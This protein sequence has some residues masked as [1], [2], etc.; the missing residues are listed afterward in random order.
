MTLGNIDPEYAWVVRL[1]HKSF[2]KWNN[3]CES[4]MATTQEF[5][6]TKEYFSGDES[7]RFVFVFRR[8]FKQAILFT[9]VYINSKIFII[10][11]FHETLATR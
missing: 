5:C 2:V 1:P 10:I 4:G 8:F 6:E 3:M 11:L 7:C 9:V